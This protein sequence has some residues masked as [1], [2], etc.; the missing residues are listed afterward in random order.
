MIGFRYALAAGSNAANYIAAG[1]N[2][3]SASAHSKYCQKYSPN[4]TD[5]FDQGLKED[6]KNF[7]Q[8]VQ[9]KSDIARTGINAKLV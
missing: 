9:S 5:I 1:R 8:M 6:A 2:A 7:Q 3:A 4:Y